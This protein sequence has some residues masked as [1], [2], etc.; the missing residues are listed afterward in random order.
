MFSSVLW[1]FKSFCLALCLYNILAVNN[2]ANRGRLQDS[3]GMWNI[4][5]YVWFPSTLQY[6]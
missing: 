3:K 1:P 4:F 5:I 6:C 2:V